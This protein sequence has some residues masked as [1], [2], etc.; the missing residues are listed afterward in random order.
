MRLQRAYPVF[1]HAE[2]PFGMSDTDATRIEVDTSVLACELVA[3]GS[4]YAVMIERF[5]KGAIEAGRAIRIM[6]DPVPLD[7]SHF[8]VDTKSTTVK[9]VSA[10]IEAFKEWVRA[11]FSLSG[12][13]QQ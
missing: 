10:E 2:L 12:L 1:N 5:A 13:H 7:Q 6:G 4:G 11:E 3:S 9:T 8:I